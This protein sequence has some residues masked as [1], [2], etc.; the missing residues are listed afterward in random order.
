MKQS[1]QGMSAILAATLACLL[2]SEAVTSSS[3]LT[4]QSG[5]G[6]HFDGNARLMI[7]VEENDALDEANTTD[8]LVLYLR[9]M[10]VRSSPLS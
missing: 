6:G 2:S 1:K 9:H 8:P 4:N 10:E 3:A 7:P 5:D